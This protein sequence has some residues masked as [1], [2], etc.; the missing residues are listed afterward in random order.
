MEDNI[1]NRSNKMFEQGVELEV[2]SILNSNFFSNAAHPAHKAIGF[3]AVSEYIQGKL[4]LEEAISLINVK[5]RQ[6]AKRQ[7]TWFRNQMHDWEILELT[8]K[9]GLREAAK[10]IDSM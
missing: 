7:R 5:T 4:G 2:K 3:S 6:Y 9:A 10:H 1:S 8:T